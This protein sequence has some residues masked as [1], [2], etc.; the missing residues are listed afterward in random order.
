[1]KEKTLE[2]DLLF[3]YIYIEMDIC[4]CGEGISHSDVSVY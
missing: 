2:K 4:I 1:M 3:I